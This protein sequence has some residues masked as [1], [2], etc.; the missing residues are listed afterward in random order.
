MRLPAAV[1]NGTEVAGDIGWVGAAA[2]LSLVVVAVAISMWKGLEVERSI[3]WACL[4]AAVQLVAVGALF[5]LIFQSAQAMT[6]AWAWVIGMTLLS[7]E[8]VARRARQIPGLR[9]Y[10]LLALAGA[11]TVTLAML[12]GFGV[13][14]LAPVTL[15]VIAGITL[16]NTLPAAVQAAD[17]ISK[18]F[19]N[20]PQRI[21]ALLA[22]GFDRAG[23]TRMTTSSAVR[24]ALVPQIERTKVIG[25]I[26]L[27]GTMTG[28]LLAGADP[29]PAVLAQLVIT[30]LVLGSVGVATSVIVTVI[31][32]RAFTTDLRLA[33][34]VTR[35]R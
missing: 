30:Y 1:L 12:F 21:E 2:S 9:I 7:S 14:D 27:P 20:E 16:G 13:F 33:D 31:A 4:R 10:A 3:I 24:L 23:A 8:V 26:A 28:M 11:V 25:L 29:I 32:A 19:I 15:V 5:G 35:A 17:T 22:L 34:W 18:E 6:W